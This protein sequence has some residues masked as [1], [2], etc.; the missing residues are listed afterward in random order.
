MS[1]SAAHMA[2]I[3]GRVS[4]KRAK[5]PALVGDEFIVLKHAPIAIGDKL[6]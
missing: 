5:D 4:K 3:V 1:E 6:D 2:G